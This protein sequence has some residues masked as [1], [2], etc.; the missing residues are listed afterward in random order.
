MR[1]TP[2]NYNRIGMTLGQRGRFVE[3][4][5]AFE[6]AIELDPSNVE[7]HC[8]LGHALAAI[9]RP[10][11]SLDAMREAVA[12]IPGSGKAHYNLGVA[13]E[14]LLMWDAAADAY[15]RSIALNP[16][17]PEAHTRLA[18]LCLFILGKPDEAIE[19][20]N[21]A[22]ELDPTDVRVQKA[23]DDAIEFVVR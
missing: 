8:G 4:I 16:L 3:A 23:L 11:E 7:P 15:R 14:R 10:E 2:S 13:A 18:N 22:L 19:S 21:A 5:E 1:E 6:R 20:L 17:R 9:G 12:A